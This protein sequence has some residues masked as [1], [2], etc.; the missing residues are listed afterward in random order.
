MSGQR[1][2]AREAFWPDEALTAMCA[3][4]DDNRVLVGTAQGRL[5]LFDFRAEHKGMHGMVRK[6]KGCVGSVRSVACARQ[7]GHFAAVGLDRFLR[8]FA[9]DSK[10]IVAKMYLKSRLNAVV[11]RPDFD[12]RRE[13]EAANV[14]QEEAGAKAEA[15]QPMEAEDGGDDD[16]EVQVLSDGSE[17]P[18]K[19]QEEDPIWKNMA[20]IGGGKKRKKTGAAAD[21]KKKKK[22]ATA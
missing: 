13:E 14:I 11:L 15:E 4:P 2:P 7:S 19:K 9:V 3:T 1:R 18:K 20:V 12:P 6:Y 8:V 10:K 21:K 5:A 17:E 22:G 16:D